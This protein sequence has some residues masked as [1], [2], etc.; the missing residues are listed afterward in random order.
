MTWESKTL[1]EAKMIMMVNYILLDESVINLSYD[2]LTVLSPTGV[3][4]SKA[5]TSECRVKINKWQMELAQRIPFS[6]SGACFFASYVKSYV[7]ILILIWACK[8]P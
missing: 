4:Q 7:T 3:Q 5:M 8:V 1:Y 2:R 6:S